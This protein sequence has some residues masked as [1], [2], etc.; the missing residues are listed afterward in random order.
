MK[1]ATFKGTAL[2]FRNYLNLMERQLSARELEIK[3]GIE[4]GKSVKD[5]VD[6]GYEK[7]WN[8]DY[9]YGFDE[10]ENIEEPK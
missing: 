2:E 5:M 8:A 1:I 9:R 7:E 4:E 6:R 3:R 10:G